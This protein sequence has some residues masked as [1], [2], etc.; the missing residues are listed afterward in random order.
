MSMRKRMTGEKV[1]IDVKQVR[2]LLERIKPQLSQEDHQLLCATTDVLDLVT[3]ELRKRGTT[4]ARLRSMLGQRSSEKT[5][6]VFGKD[7]AASTSDQAASAPAGEPLSGESNPSAPAGSGSAPS[8]RPKRKGHGRIPASSYDCEFTPVAHPTLCAGHQCPDCAHGSLYDT[9]QPA[10]SVIVVGRPLLAA[11]GFEAQC[12]RCNSC[13]KVFT[14]P[15]PERARGPKYTP[16]AAAMITVAH[17]WLG[18]PFYRLEGAQRFLGVPVPA[19]TQWEVVRDHLPCVMPVYD[20]LTSLAADAPVVHN[21]DTWVKILALMGK[22]RRELEATGEFERPDRTGLFTTAVVA[23]TSAGS[24]VLFASG[25]AHAGEN[26]ADLLDQRDPQLPP[27]IQMCD[28]L[29]RNLPPD[30]TVVHANC[31][32]HARR[33]IVDEAGD[34]PELCRHILGQIG[35]VFHN[36]HLCKLQGL[37]RDARLEYHQRESGPV[38]EGLKNWI[39]DL[40]ESKRVEPNSGLG[41]ALSYMTKRWDKLTLFLRVSDAPV[42]NNI[43]ERSI[44]MLIRLRRAS[45]F[46]ATTKGALVGDVFTA[47][48]YTTLLH[49]GDPFRYLT[50]LFAHDKEV[51]AAPLEWLPWNYQDALSRIDQHRLRAA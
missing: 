25:R 27:P 26:L 46:Y 36:E 47:L 16:S 2:G 51:E 40:V 44:K 38:M 37:T 33:R 34:H 6:D 7:T 17:Y 21:D 45:L 3:R 11:E 5:A 39:D 42:E 1:T 18:L 35:K 8:P 41:D 23:Q 10:P 14:A 29:D 22:R 19:A 48:I 24:I 28:G 9:H 13:G 30:H 50:A 32:S 20:V 4:I 31:M 12:L 49:G 43:A 15:L